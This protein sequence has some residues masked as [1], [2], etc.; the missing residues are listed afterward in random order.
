M[1]IKI[2]PVRRNLR[3]NLPKGK[4]LTW[5]PAGL[6]VTQFFNTLSIFFPAGERFFI[7]SVRNYREEIADQKLKEQVS[8]FIGQEAFHTREHEEYNEALQEAGLPVQALERVVERLLANTA[9][10]P[11]SAQLAITV[12]LEHLTAVLGDVLL[13]NEVLLKDVEPHFAALWR[14]HAIEETEHKAVCF[15]AFEGVIAGELRAYGLR[16][17]AF[18]LANMLFWSLFVPFYAVMLARSGGLFDL[19]GWLSVMNLVAGRPGVLRRALP[20]WFS[21]FR[22]G[23]HPWQHDNREFLAQAETLMNNLSGDDLEPQSAA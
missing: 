18:V 19:R 12:A 23:F 6:H 20:D 5:H 9:R 7:Q 16:V 13:R 21:F 22:P 4:A 3:F 11:R 8:A 2:D 10:L 14:W 15:D 1:S 17:V